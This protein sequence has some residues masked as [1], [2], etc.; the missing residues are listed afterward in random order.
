MSLIYGIA[1]LS[2]RNVAKE[3]CKALAKAINEED[4]D[5]NS[6]INGNLF[7][8]YGYKRGRRQRAG[9]FRDKRLTVLADIRIYNSDVLKKDFEFFTP[10][11][12]LAK[13]YIRWGLDC[14]NHINGDFAAVIIDNEKG[15]LHLIRDHVGVRP[16]TYSISGNSIIFASHE[17]GIAGSCLIKTSLSE[18]EVTRQFFRSIKENYE[19]TIFEH[20]NSVLPGNII[21]ISFDKDCGKKVSGSETEDLNQVNIKK[22][23]YWNPAKF[24][25]RKDLTYEAAVTSLRELLIKATK[26]RMENLPT[27]LHVSGGI[28]STGVSSIVADMA[29][30]KSLLTGYS[31]APEEI[32]EEI[33]GVNEKEFIEEFVKEKGIQVKYQKHDEKEVFANSVIPEFGVQNIENSLMKVAS[34]DG[35]E[36][37]FSGWGGDEFLSLST[38]GTFNHLFFTFQWFKL[39]AFVKK[40]GIRTAINKFYIEVLPLLVPFGLVNPFKLQKMDWSILKFL[41]KE[42]I[43]RNFKNIFFNRK[44]NIFGWGNRTRFALNLLENYHL[45]KRMDCWA[46]NGEKYGL[47]Y[48]YPL[49]DKDL[50]EFWFSI[51][52]EYTYKDF[53]SRLLYR[54]IMKGILA[55]KTRMRKDK[56][57]TILQTFSLSAKQQNTGLLI[58]NYVQLE[59]DAHLPYFRQESLLKHI[60]RIRFNLNI[61]GIRDYAKFVLYLRLVN[62]TKKYNVKPS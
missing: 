5:N 55:E 13:A 11:E 37:V 4:F 16:L 50:L 25:T 21:T 41:K 32:G 7:C 29:N 10:E 48:R 60:S 57:D 56:S 15:E 52:V 47:D 14:G 19:Q 34:Q 6:I 9:I 38:R 53:F 39:M 12:A 58:D 45:T 61:N 51:P 28:D 1:D 40:T 2:G 46:I 62:L 17:F 27:A 49:L 43:V 22:Y 54:D 20:I 26:A 42:F 36:I 3:N 8:G 18:D 24:S 59:K 33:T 35:A 31:Y 44:H 23:R 30:D